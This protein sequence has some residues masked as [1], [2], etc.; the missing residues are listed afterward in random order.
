MSEYKDFLVFEINW[1]SKFGYALDLDRPMAEIWMLM[2]IK[3]KQIA[4]A[5]DR[6][7]KRRGG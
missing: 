4:E 3:N 2:A 7:K 1:Q 5:R 6:A